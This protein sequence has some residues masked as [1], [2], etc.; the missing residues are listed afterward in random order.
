[1]AELAVR[2]MLREAK[3]EKGGIGGKNGIKALLV[4]MRKDQQWRETKMRLL[5][6]LVGLDFLGRNYS[7]QNKTERHWFKGYHVYGSRKEVETRFKRGRPISCFCMGTDAGVRTV[8]VAFKDK[9]TRSSNTTNQTAT[10]SY[11]TYDIVDIVDG[12]KTN[13][14]ETG[15]HFCKFIPRENGGFQSRFDQKALQSNIMGHALMLPYISDISDDGSYN[16]NGYGDLYTLVYSDWE[17]LRCT[18]VG[19]RKC[20]VGVEPS[21]FSGVM[22]PG[23]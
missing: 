6:K 13:T 4:S 2:I 16:S 18:G 10:I 5:H 19:P 11:L 17:V 20:R 15:V 22:N 21:V 9:E 1:M 7:E 23:N 3:D 14:R 8:H 12:I